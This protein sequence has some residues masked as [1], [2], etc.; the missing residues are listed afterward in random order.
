MAF[1]CLF[2]KA[3]GVLNELKAEAWRSDLLG[4]VVSLYRLRT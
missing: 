1:V 2:L 3:V 4:E